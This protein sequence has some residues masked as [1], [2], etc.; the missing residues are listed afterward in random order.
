[1]YLI[2]PI[3]IVVV[4]ISFVLGRKA[5]DRIV[6]N[7]SPF[8]FAEDML[9]IQTK[10]GFSAQ[11]SS[12]SCIELYYNPKTLQNRFYDMKIQIVKTDGSRKNICY[13]GSGSGALPQDM[14]AA[15]T[16]HHIKYAVKDS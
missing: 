3:L 15:L 7:L 10:T 2:I 4:V 5:Q 13:K 11:V 9:I 12:I 16:A 1:M 8:S 14:A 6:S